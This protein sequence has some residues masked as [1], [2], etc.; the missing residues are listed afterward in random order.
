MYFAVV[1]PAVWLVYLSL[2]LDLHLCSPPS[3][4]PLGCSSGSSPS[5]GGGAKGKS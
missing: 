4:S 1:A 3:L 2:R 5:E